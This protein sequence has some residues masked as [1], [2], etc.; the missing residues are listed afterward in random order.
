MAPAVRD[1]SGAELGSALRRGWWKALL[2][3]ILGLGLAA[4]FVVTQAPTYTSVT[5]AL[6]RPSTDDATS[7]ESLAAEDLAQARAATY[8][9]LGNSVVVADE[10]RR[11]LGLKTSPEDLLEQV[12]VVSTPETTGLEITATAD[13][14]D[15]AAE[16]AGTWRDA[17]SDAADADGS[18]GAGDRVSIEPAGSRPCPRRRRACPIRPS[19]WSAGR[20]GCSSASWWRWVPPGRRA[21]PETARPPSDAGPPSAAAQQLLTRYQRNFELP[22]A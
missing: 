14:A 6:V 7:V 1:I 5:M 10:V 11:D 3:L 12:T 4:A 9:S 8:E 13:S 22:T 19:W 18:G 16:L 17:L 21:G 20:W 15:G 2:G